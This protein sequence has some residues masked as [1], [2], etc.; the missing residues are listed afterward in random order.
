MK[1]WQTYLRSIALAINL[2]V[3]FVSNA[4]STSDAIPTI[5]GDEQEFALHLKQKM[6]CDHHKLPNQ[7]SG[8]NVWHSWS[9]LDSTSV[10]KFIESL[11]QFNSV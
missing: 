4:Q 5:H 7:I 11:K 6:D 10:S 3:N 1:R 9:K 8:V 2:T